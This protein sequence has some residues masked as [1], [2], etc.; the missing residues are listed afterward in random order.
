MIAFGFKYYS[1]KPYKEIGEG[2]HFV[3]PNALR[4]KTSLFNAFGIGMG[5]PS[6]YFGKNWDAF[7]DCLMDLSWIN[8]TTVHIAHEEVPALPLLDAQIYLKVLS[9]AIKK[10]KSEQTLLLAK[11]FPEFK[12]HKLFVYFPHEER[13]RIA[14]LCENSEQ[15]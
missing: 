13:K 9:I 2:F 1:D 7:N 15:E 5:A 4:D 12:P 14:C 10:W 6:Q 11:K 8:Q 3:V